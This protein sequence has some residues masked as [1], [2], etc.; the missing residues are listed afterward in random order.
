MDVTKD[1][2][3]AGSQPA[4]QDLPLPATLALGRLHP[5]AFG[6][7]VGVVAG[8][9]MLLLTLLTYSLA[10]VDAREF[11]GLLS[12]YL[13]GY[14]VTPLGALIGSAYGLIIGWVV[15][16]LFAATRNGLILTYLRYLYRRVEQDRLSDLLDRMT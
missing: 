2:A 4:Q 8:L 10:T 15:A 6:L 14:R 3:T 16:Y 5:R 11:L 12:Q 7:A 13:P 9:W 1:S